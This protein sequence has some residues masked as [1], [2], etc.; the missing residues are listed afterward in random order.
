MWILQFWQKQCLLN[1]S[2]H[3][4]W[5]LLVCV[6]VCV[7]QHFCATLLSLPSQTLCILKIKKAVFHQP[8]STFPCNMKT[9]RTFL[10]CSTHS[11]VHDTAVWTMTEHISCTIHSVASFLGSANSAEQ[12]AKLITWYGC[13]SSSGL[14]WKMTWTR[15][16]QR[17]TDWSLLTHHTL[18]WGQRIVCSSHFTDCCSNM[19][20]PLQLGH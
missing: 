12:M 13:S 14:T 8:H 7:T 2:C 1:T 20:F 10:Y 19:T 16:D 3:A 4:S 5:L 17:K 18:L 11:F 9:T 6:C 15:A